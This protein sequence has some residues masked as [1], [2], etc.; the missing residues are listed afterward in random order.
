MLTTTGKRFTYEA[1]HDEDGNI[2]G[3]FIRET[4]GYFAGRTPAEVEAIAET[5]Y[6]ELDPEFKHNAMQQEF[7]DIHFNHCVRRRLNDV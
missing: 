6:P 4:A 5:L 7:R 2:L 1:E 3:T